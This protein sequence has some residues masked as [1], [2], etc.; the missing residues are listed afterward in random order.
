MPLIGN[1]LR[2]EVSSEVADR[3]PSAGAKALQIVHQRTRQL[4]VD[5]LRKASWVQSPAVFRHDADA[6][7][8][9]GS[10]TMQF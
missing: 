7:M 3:S 4:Q 9:D 2:E 8:A 1:R 5:S 6:G 10:G